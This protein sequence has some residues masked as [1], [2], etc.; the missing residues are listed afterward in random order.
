MELTTSE[1][2]SRLRFLHDVNLKIA[3]APGYD[4]AVQHV[5]AAFRYE[6]G[7][8][9]G[10]MWDL[11]PD[12]A[13]LVLTSLQHD[14]QSEFRD[15]ESGLR[16]KSTELGSGAVGMAWQSGKP[17]LSVGSAA[18]VSIDS[19]HDTQSRATDQRILLAIPIRCEGDLTS[20]I[21]LHVLDPP[22]QSRLDRLLSIESE[23][24]GYLR[25]KWEDQDAQFAAVIV[26]Q[27][28]TVLYRALAIDGAPRVSIRHPM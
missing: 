23:L 11:S 17:C 24:G 14:G 20:V 1:E 22:H 25:R 18:P 6:L 13:Q 2:L 27:S 10:E 19:L 26:E 21:G 16:S 8:D 7:A 4:A 5:I 9:C 15:L 3:E 28:P 12:G